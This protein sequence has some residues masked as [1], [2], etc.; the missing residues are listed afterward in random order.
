M[1]EKN[2]AL[3]KKTRFFSFEQVCLSSRDY[4]VIFGLSVIIVLCRVALFIPIFLEWKLTE[5]QKDTLDT[6]FALQG[7]VMVYVFLSI[8]IIFGLR[9]IVGYLLKKISQ[10]WKKQSVNKTKQTV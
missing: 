7:V 1:K 10:N 5:W 6:V 4:K 3:D 2:W 9:I 8:P